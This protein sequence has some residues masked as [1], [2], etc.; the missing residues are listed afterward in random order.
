MAG[1]S[2]LLDLREVETF[3]F[4]VLAFVLA[5]QCL[6][7]AGVVGTAQFPD[8]FLGDVATDILTVVG[9]VLLLLFFDFAEQF[10]AGHIVV[11]GVVSRG[12]RNA[13]DEGAW[14]FRLD[15]LAEQSAD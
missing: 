12:R 10:E 8:N 5:T 6:H 9:L 13:D 1:A 15:G 7:M 2:H 11:S 4:L 14:P 3:Y